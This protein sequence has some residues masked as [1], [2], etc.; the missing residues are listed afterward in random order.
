MRLRHYFAFVVLA[1]ISPLI[2]AH[3]ILEFTVGKALDF[4]FDILDH[5]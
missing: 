5:V 1:L 3:W 2:L 4:V